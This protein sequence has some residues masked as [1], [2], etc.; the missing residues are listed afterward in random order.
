MLQAPS[1]CAMWGNGGAKAVP[2]AQAFPAVVGGAQQPRASRTIPG[3]E[4]KPSLGQRSFNARKGKTSENSFWS[5]HPLGLC[6]ANFTRGDPS[7]RI[8]VTEGKVIDR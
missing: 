4:A 3:Q 1:T 2:L 8:P 5:Q 6:V 7:T